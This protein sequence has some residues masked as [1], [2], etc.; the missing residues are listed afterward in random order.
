MACGGRTPALLG[1]GSQLRGEG[2]EETVW[3]LRVRSLVFEAS[4]TVCMLAGYRGAGV[5]RRV[6]TPSPLAGA[7]ACLGVVYGS[8][9]CGAT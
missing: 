4:W 9:A 8:T 1:L 2:N 3:A 7:A 6:A 5:P